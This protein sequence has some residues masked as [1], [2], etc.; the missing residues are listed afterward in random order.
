VN[1]QAAG[2]PRAILISL[3]MAALNC[4][5]TPPQYV[6]P[7]TP[8]AGAVPA[9]G[10]SG[11]SPDGAG[12]AGGSSGAE[13]AAGAAA[14]RDGAAGGAADARAEEAAPSPAAPEAGSGVDGAPDG[15]PP[16]ACVGGDGRCA[17]GCTHTE[18]PDCVEP[19]RMFVTSTTFTGNLGGVDG[20]DLKCA[21]RARAAG[22]PGRFVAFLA[23]TGQSPFTR[24]AGASGWVR[25]DGRPFGNTAEDLR[26]GRGFFPPLLDELARQVPPTDFVLTGISSPSGEPDPNNTC[27][28]WGAASANETNA[29]GS[30]AAGGSSWFAYYTQLPCD[31]TSV[32]LHLYCFEL[33]RQA[34]V[35]LRPPGAGDRA[36]FVT[37]QAF[38][39]SAG[40]AGADLLCNDEAGRAGLAGS[41]RALL[42]T[43][44]RPA[45]S[46]FGLGGPPWM[47]VD[48]VTIVRNA[49]ELGHAPLLAALDRDAQGKLARF[50]PW[51]GAL[52]PTQLGDATCRD[53]TS[54]DPAFKGR[55]GDGVK[56]TQEWFAGPLAANNPNG[57][58][59]PFPVYCLQ[60]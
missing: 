37:T 44:A 55:F 24:L 42:A 23:T 38:R 27:N 15:A 1:R 40:L 52:S 31:A 19:N 36:A 39:P 54:S 59:R 25:T 21:E 8:D 45:L 48:G 34:V 51:T 5:S 3:A 47:R 53:W 22:L 16:T 18:D 30:P 14:G 35:S 17:P 41:F 12:G 57:C 11:G 9:G 49:A 26:Q 10:A 20:A 29:G 13:G 46:R 58:D 43:N 60:E 32:G 28:D 56:T 33:S 6:E 7:Q 2:V 50:G 4:I